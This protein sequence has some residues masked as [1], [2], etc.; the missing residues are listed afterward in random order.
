[1]LE[2]VEASVEPLLLS[3]EAFFQVLNEFLIHTASAV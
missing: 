3:V 1:L 2:T